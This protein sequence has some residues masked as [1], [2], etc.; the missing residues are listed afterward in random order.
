MDLGAPK[1]RLC[2]FPVENSKTLRF[3]RNV[4]INGYNIGEAL[5]ED[6]KQ[7]LIVFL[8]ELFQMKVHVE[9]LQCNRFFDWLPQLSLPC[10]IDNVFRLYTSILLPET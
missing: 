6:F 8:V 1:W 4:V 10:S 5:M 3:R 7:I 9:Y 2:G